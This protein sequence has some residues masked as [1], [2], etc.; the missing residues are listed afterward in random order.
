MLA[1]FGPSYMS[2]TAARLSTIQV[3]TTACAMRKAKKPSAVVAKMQPNVASKNNTNDAIIT[4]RRPI[5][6][7]IGPTTIWITVL[8]AR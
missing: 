7:E 6:S 5:L 1:A 3:A 8:A 2:R 4:G